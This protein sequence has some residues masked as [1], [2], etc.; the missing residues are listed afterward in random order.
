MFFHCRAPGNLMKMWFYSR[1]DLGKMTAEHKM[2]GSA[3]QVN[4]TSLVWSC[5]TEISAAQAAVSYN[6]DWG[7]GYT[8][9]MYCLTVLE[10]RASCVSAASSCW[11][12]EERLFSLVSLLFTGDWSTPV[13]LH[14]YVMLYLCKCVC[15]ADFFSY[16]DTSQIGLWAHLIPS[17]RTSF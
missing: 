17:K 15:T 16:K 1:V 6:L 4:I 7:V 14:L 8:T 10:P 5:V 13:M 3:I 2:L 11:G 12:Y 9:E